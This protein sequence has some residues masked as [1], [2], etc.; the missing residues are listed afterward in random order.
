MVEGD[1]KKHTP[2]GQWADA[3]V[4]TWSRLRGLGLSNEQI[5]KALAPVV[6]ASSSMAK[7]ASVPPPPMSEP[8]LR[9]RTG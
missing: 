3:L 4:L 2:E 9:R 7:A 1:G 6:A 8:R 5:E